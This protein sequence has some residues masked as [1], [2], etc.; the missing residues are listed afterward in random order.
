MIKQHSSITELFKQPT[1]RIIDQSTLGSS[2]HALQSFAMDDTLCTSI[3]SEDAP[4]TVRAWV[5]PK[6]VV[7]GIQDSRVPFLTEGL[8]FLQNQGYEVIVRNSGG[9]AVVLDEGVLNLSLVVPE[10]ERRIG[11]DS[12]Y[13]AMAHLTANL[14][15]P[16]GLTFDTKEIA[17]SYCPGKFDLS[18]DG[19]KFAGI[20]QR[21]LRGGVAVQIYLCVNGSG[22]SRA[23]LV[24]GFYNR[25]LQESETKFTYPSVDP[26][27]MASLEELTGKS[28]QVSD[29]MKGLLSFLKMQGAELLSSQ[30][31]VSEI[32]LYDFYL[33]RVVERNEKAMNS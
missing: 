2:F 23:E 6:T 9:L 22:A 3:G 7:L 29:L 17:T 13:E 5:H 1:W 26:N 25:A 4:P 16:Y 19:K 33:K 8:Q 11:I 20:S 31:S 10:K 18:V 28:V 14:L 30:L 27:V 24:K 15:S 21:R 12:G 32:N